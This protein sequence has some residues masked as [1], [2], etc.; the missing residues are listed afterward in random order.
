MSKPKGEPAALIRVASI[1]QLVR[2]SAATALALCEESGLKTTDGTM[3]FEAETT[4]YKLKI[5]RK[6][7][8][9]PTGGLVT[10]DGKPM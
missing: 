8:L 10:P 6:L 5:E 9:S 7:V 4:N 3:L 1:V 2:N